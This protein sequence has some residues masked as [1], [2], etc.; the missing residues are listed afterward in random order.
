[1]ARW[2]VAHFWPAK[3]PSVHRVMQLRLHNPA[4]KGSQIFLALIL[5][6]DVH[7]DVSR[8]AS[9]W[10]Q[11]GCVRYNRRFLSELAPVHGSHGSAELGSRGNG[12]DAGDDHPDAIDDHKVEPEVQRLW[13]RVDPSCT[14]NTLI[15]KPGAL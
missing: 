8:Q 7:A 4:C 11:V 12:N 13:P 6:V 3:L 5:R 2:S 1:M 10:P 9:D 15:I 14:G